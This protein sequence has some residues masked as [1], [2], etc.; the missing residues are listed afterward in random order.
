[1][2]VSLI[3]LRRARPGIASYVCVG[4]CICTYVAR[5]LVLE[6]PFS[7]PETPKV[8]WVRLGRGGGWVESRL[9]FSSASARTPELDAPLAD[10]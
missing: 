9:L 3:F 2:G 8:G 10:E 6:V 1:M 7:W 4:L 5:Y